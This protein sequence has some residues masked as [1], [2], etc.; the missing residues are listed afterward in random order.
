MVYENVIRSKP[1]AMAEDEVQL[2][3]SNEEPFQLGSSHASSAEAAVFWDKVVSALEPSWFE[4][5]VRRDAA[6]VRNELQRLGLLDVVKGGR[7]TES[8]WNS[9]ENHPPEELKLFMASQI[10]TQYLEKSLTAI[11]TRGIALD[12]ALRK[13]ERNI[14]QTHEIYEGI[15]KERAR[16]AAETKKVSEE[17]AECDRLLK[18]NSSP[19]RS[20]SPRAVQTPATTGPRGLDSDG[21]VASYGEQRV[22]EAEESPWE[23]TVI[24]RMADHHIRS[25]LIFSSIASS[26]MDRS[27]GFHTGFLHEPSSPKYIRSRASSLTSSADDEELV[28]FASNSTHGWFYDRNKDTLA[29]KAPLE[30]ITEGSRDNIDGEGDVEEEND[31]FF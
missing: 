12:E 16:I 31:E 15:R 28:L 13:V 29:F 9:L 25:S 20:I 10:A 18:T 19:S 24:P 11:R 1:N 7:I 3:S 4:E 8:E 2:R 5:I 22:A 14:K 21:S 30:G 6:T 23:D 27:T 17:I 26:P